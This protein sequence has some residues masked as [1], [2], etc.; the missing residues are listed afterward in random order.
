MES[1]EEETKR[2]SDPMF[3]VEFDLVDVLTGGDAANAVESGGYVSIVS[4]HGSCPSCV[5]SRHDWLNWAKC[6]CAQART[7]FS[8]LI[9][10]HENPDAVYGQEVV[11]SPAWSSEGT[12]QMLG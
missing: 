3:D 9:L 6:E 8:D 5:L 1:R 2:W 7:D 12:L 10:K 11:P 4:Q